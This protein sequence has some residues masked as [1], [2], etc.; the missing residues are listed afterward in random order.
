MATAEDAEFSVGLGGD[1]TAAVEA[2][3]GQVTLINYGE[4]TSL[5]AGQQVRVS[6]SQEP[7]LSSIPASLLLEVAWPTDSTRSD[8]RRLA[9][10]TEPGASV[11]TVVRGK[12]LR[13]V[14]DSDGNFV[15]DGV[16]LQEG[17]NTIEVSARGIL[18]GEGRAEGRVD[19]DSEAP[20]GAFRVEY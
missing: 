13:A 14:A 11:W 2:R 19:R 17:E 5:E 20:I 18:G 12:R 4:I 15:I 3:E 8:Q 1:G 9:G 16:P 10:R 7:A 6:P